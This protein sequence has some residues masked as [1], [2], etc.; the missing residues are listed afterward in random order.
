MLKKF[1]LATFIIASLGS[2]VFSANARTNLT[3]SLTV[4]VEGLK[5][6]T[7]EVCLAIF[8]GS[9]GFPSG[10]QDVVKSQCILIDNNPLT[11]TFGDLPFGSYA[12][13]IY[14]DFNQ[15]KQLNQN[16][17]GIPTEGFGFSNDAPIRTGP[18]KYEEAMFLLTASQ[19]TINIRM[20]YI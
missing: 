20:R 19:T 10:S 3:G 5:N 15:D 9:R 17:L 2:I 12:V 18:A 13:A 8:S 16:F 6:Q 1:S 11:V 14:H 4:Q 7:G